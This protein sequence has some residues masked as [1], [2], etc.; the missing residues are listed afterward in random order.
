MKLNEKYAG[1]RTEIYPV[2]IQ[3]YKAVDH[4]VE[5]AVSQFGQ[6]DILVNN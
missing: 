1:L 5:A 3:D 6:I 2:D 4:V